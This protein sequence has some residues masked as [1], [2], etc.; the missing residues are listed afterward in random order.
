MYD[1]LSEDERK[2]GGKERKGGKEEVQG[3]FGVFSGSAG[4]RD[5]RTVILSNLGLASD[6]LQ[7][8]L[9]SC[10]APV[11]DCLPY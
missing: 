10:R 2:E 5:G 3:S 7:T 8:P 4:R 1:R 11:R 9:L 6:T